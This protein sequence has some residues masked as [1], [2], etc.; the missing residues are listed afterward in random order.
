[1]S[2][3]QQLPDVR[4]EYRENYPLAPITWLKVGGNAEV[5]FKPRDLDD[6]IAFLKSAPKTI[7]LTVLGACS[8]V[9]IRDRGVDG[10]VIK[11]GREFAGIELLPENKIKIGAAMLN[12]NTA[13]FCLKN[14][15]EGFEFLIGI[16]GTAGGG[17]AMNAGAYTR[18]FKDI[19][20]EIEAV[21]RA[22]EVVNV[23][24]DQIGFGYRKNSLPSDLI[25]V[26]VTCKYNVGDQAMIQSRMDQI[27][28]AR[29]ATQPI[30]EKTCGS[31][32][33]NPP[34]HKAWQ[35]I[36]AVGMKGYILGDAQVSDL[37]ANFMINRG[38]A[39]AK[40]IEDLGE[41]IR[42]KV[43]DLKGIE[44][45]WEVKKIGKNA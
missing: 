41:L 35:L 2:L 8:N 43:R 7:E 38:A 37:H 4:G 28:S 23:S 39:T 29:M 21:N 30:K 33:A 40:D 45:T 26:S 10:V 42:Q 12:Y 18:E 31:T 1:M 36:E 19:V 16:P 34:G 22:G 24:N 6:L 13:Q 15:I 32:F 25:I 44:L 27:V 20:F 17:V 11:L 14:S 3:L 5:F 9:L